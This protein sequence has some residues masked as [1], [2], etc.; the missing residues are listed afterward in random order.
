M[1]QVRISD[2]LLQLKPGAEWSVNGN[3]YEGINW[4]DKTQTKPTEDEVNKKI[5]ELKAAEPMNLLRE[6]RDRLIAQSDW[7]IVRAKETS[8]NIPAAWK[9][10]R[11]ALRDLPASSNP[12]LNS[13]G[14]LD[15]TSVTW[16]TKPS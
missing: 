14:Y 11:Q 13:E 16:P 9:T 12:K 3:T 1:S 6:E 7:M 15:M 5:D 2:A 4:L 8:T 10:Y